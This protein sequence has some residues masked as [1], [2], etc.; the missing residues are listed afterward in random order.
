[1]ADI[2]IGPHRYDVIDGWGRLPTGIDFRSVWSAAVGSL[3]NPIWSLAVD[4]KD[5]VYIFQ[6]NDPPVVV[7]D[8]EGNFLNSWG[9]GAVN[10]G[11]GI[12]I[13]PDDSVYMTDQDD[14]VVIKYTLEGR[15]LLV[16]GNRGRASDTGYVRSTRT[17]LRAAAPFN[18]P[19]QVATAPSG[20]FYVSDGYANSRI[21]RFS[22]DGKLILS[23]G[24]PGKAAPGEFHAP[25]GIWVDRDNQVYVCDRDNSRVQAFNADG[26]FL[27]QWANQMY[28]PTSIYMDAAETVYVSESEGFLGQTFPDRRQIGG[29]I[30]VWNKEGKKLGGLDGPSVHWVH[31]DSQGDLYA[32][33]PYREGIKKYVRRG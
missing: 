27:G 22:P 26:K 8:R 28:R 17:I 29:R 23:W 3:I 2:P 33:E 15:P 9:N 6:R 20:D 5:R 18:M 4:S 13:G 25:H 24:N 7:F 14:H 32:V 21:H 1:M 16:L 30:S 10:K 19:T 12:H 31:G 11:H